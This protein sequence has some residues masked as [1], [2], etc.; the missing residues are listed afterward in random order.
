MLFAGKRG[1]KKGTDLFSPTRSALS[2]SLYTFASQLLNF[3]D[4][5]RVARELSTLQCVANGL[6][7]CRIDNLSNKR[8]TAPPACPLTSTNTG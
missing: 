2:T 7:L 3:L 6:P 1:R 4:K 8:L 5:S